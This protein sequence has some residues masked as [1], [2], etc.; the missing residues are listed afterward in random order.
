MFIDVVER[1]QHLAIN[2][3]IV[4]DIFPKT[5]SHVIGQNLESEFLTLNFC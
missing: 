3:Y 1:V 4:K 5:V 2:H